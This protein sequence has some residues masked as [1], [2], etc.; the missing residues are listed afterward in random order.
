ME[1]AAANSL[2]AKALPFVEQI[3]AIDRE[4]ETLTGEHMARCK[5]KREE[6]K[7]IYGE[8]KDA[9]LGTRPLKGIVKQRKLQRKI[10]AI[11][12]DFDIDESATYREL[13]ET[14]G[15]LGA[16]AAARA[17]YGDDGDLRPEFLKRQERERGPDPLD[18]ALS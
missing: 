18:A 13:A 5:A 2:G 15:P 7:T 6:K 12:A 10:E 17:G 8:A 9:G 1:H 4:L 3:E 16:A 11:P 14:L